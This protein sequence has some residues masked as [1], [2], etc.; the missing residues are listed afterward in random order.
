MHKKINN[1][2]HWLIGLSLGFFLLLSSIFIFIKQLDQKIYDGIQI[3]GIDVGLLSKEE[4]LNKLNRNN[5]LDTFTITLVKDNLQISSNSAL[6]GVYQNKNKAVEQAFL[7]GKD[8]P[9]FKKIKTI[10][11]L[12]KH[13]IQIP[14]SYNYDEKSLN[15]FLISFEEVFNI[16]TLK[17]EAIL[18]KSGD[19][20]SLTINNGG[21]GRLLLKEETKNLL[22]QQIVSNHQTQVIAEAMTAS[23]SAQL[24]QQEL[25]QAK[26]RAKKFIGKE[27]KFSADNVNLSLSDQALISLLNFPE[28][29][30]KDKLRLILISWKE[31][32]DRSP[33]N[34]VFDYDQETLKVKT[35]IPHQ[36][37][38]SLDINEIGPIVGN[39][40]MELEKSDLTDLKQ[41]IP[42]TVKTTEPEITLAKTNNLGI[43]EV[44]G[45]GE[46]YYAHSIPSRVH[47]VAITSEKVDLTLVPPGAEFSFNKTLGD[48]SAKTGY[49]AAYVISGGST[50]LSPGGGVCQVSTTTF[51]AILDAGFPVTKRLPHSYRVSYYELDNDPGFDATVYSGNTDLRF[52]N[53]TGHYILLDYSA[54]SKKLHMTTTIYGTSD[55]RSTEIINYRK[56]GY[57][58]PLATLYIPDP[59]LPKGVKKQIDWSASGIKAEFT[60]VIKDKN[61]E[62]IREDY[63]YSYY[64]PWSAKYLV[65]Q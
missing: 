50:V 64:H 46:S 7:Y 47:N 32:V 30:R 21:T 13:S 9:I 3:E 15:E 58:P 18:L 14:I 61:G 12:K 52:V 38:L 65:G 56:W 28:G 49:Q 17:P 55:G 1:T 22:I 63:Y 26:L 33:T 20:K 37:G 54:D 6:L 51:R 59:T 4:A 44:I 16:E 40:I 11:N 39:K 41:A 62:T 34:A 23:V 19:E 5:Q 24:N 10:L 8:E 48:V 2:T 45:F 43:K 25:E 36:T 35:F 60:N 27:L 53:D 29:I 42:L 57:V 31:L